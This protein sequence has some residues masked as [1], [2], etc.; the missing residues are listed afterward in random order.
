MIVTDF[1]Y[2][3]PG[4]LEAYAEMLVDMPDLTYQKI[5]SD[6]DKVKDAMLADFQAEPGKVK[7]PIQWT[8]DRQRRAFFASKGFGK[9]IPYVRTGKLA[10]AWFIHTLHDANGMITIQLGNDDPTMQFVEGE[11]QQRFHALTGWLQADDL[12]AKWFNTVEDVVETALL[13]ILIIRS[14]D[15][16]RMI[17]SKA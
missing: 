15:Q 3:D 8:S 11:N 17:Q 4:I 7:Y 1:S 14:D 6:M 13:T 5:S 10:K 16:A 12:G 2:T 9:G